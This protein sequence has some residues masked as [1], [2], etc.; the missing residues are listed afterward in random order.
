MS[1][2][3]IERL[4]NNSL[5]E[6]LPPFLVSEPGLNSGF[7]IAHCTA[8]ALTSENKVLCHPSSIDTITTSELV[9]LVYSCFLILIN[10]KCMFGLIKGSATEDHVSMG[11]WSARKALDVIRNI[12]HI[13]AIEL[14]ASCQAL[15]FLHANNLTTT[16]PLEAVY[17]MVRKHVKALDQDRF[18]APDINEAVKLIQKNEIWKCVECY[19]EEYRN[20]QNETGSIS[21]LLDY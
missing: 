19:I 17:M 12:E 18:M 10:S 1:E 3:R 5:S 7:M 4:V 14:L 21:C 13:L 2:R 11:G 6:G 9:F 20:I 8:A 16:K 15:E